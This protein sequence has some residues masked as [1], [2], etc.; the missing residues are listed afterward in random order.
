MNASDAY[1][2]AEFLVGFNAHLGFRLAEWRAD[3]AR[4]EVAITDVHLNRSGIVHGGLY[5]TMLDAA[6]GYTGVWTPPGAPRQRAVTLS[7]TTNYLAKV[8]AGKVVCE[9]RRVGGG[10]AIFYAEGVVRDDAGMVLAT[11]QSTH[12]IRTTWTEDGH[13]RAE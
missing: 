4:M 6:A 8:S 13:D 1:Q 9:S 10:R 5:A 11:G 3:Y 2:D 7:L 12:R